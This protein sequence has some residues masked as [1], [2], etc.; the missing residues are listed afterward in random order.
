MDNGG[1]IFAVIG[2]QIIIVH[3]DSIINFLHDFPL[4]SL[5]VSFDFKPGQGRDGWTWTVKY[6]LANLRMAVHIRIDEITFNVK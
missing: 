1:I 5:L 4:F 2:L 3:W 6:K